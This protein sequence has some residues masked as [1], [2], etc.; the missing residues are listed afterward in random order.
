MRF[1][2]IPEATVDTVLS[3]NSEWVRNLKSENKERLVKE[4]QDLAG[5]GAMIF[6]QG[7]SFTSTRT[8][9]LDG[10]Q[11]VI[12]ADFRKPTWFKSMLTKWGLR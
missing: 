7:G 8:L 5:N 10:N 3:Q 6:Q 12:R 1:L 9:S 2:V 4:V 11:V